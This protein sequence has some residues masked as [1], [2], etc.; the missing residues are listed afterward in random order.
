[1]KDATK[2]DDFKSKETFKEYLLLKTNPLEF[3][4]QEQGYLM[5]IAKVETGIPKC[6]KSHKFKV[7]VK[8][9]DEDEGQSKWDCKVGCYELNTWFRTPKGADGLKYKTLGLMLKAIEK[10]L[11]KYCKAKAESFEIVLN[12]NRC[13]V[14]SDVF[15]KESTSV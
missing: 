7:D 8:A 1:M 3:L 12:N 13:A 9:N 2:Y 4:V 6:F 15:L 10:G 5:V 14:D 11:V